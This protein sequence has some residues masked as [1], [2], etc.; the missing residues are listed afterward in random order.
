[1]NT[2]LIF[3]GGCHSTWLRTPALDDPHTFPDMS[4]VCDMS[5]NACGSSITWLMHSH[6]FIDLSILV[7]DNQAF[8]IRFLPRLSPVEGNGI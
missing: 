5:G 2:N 7:L 4:T 1:M 6:S 8:E 3:Q